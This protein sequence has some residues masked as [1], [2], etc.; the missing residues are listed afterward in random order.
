MLHGLLRQQHVLRQVLPELPVIK[1]L[2]L[3]RFKSIAAFVTGP[4][5]SLMSL[6]H[7]MNHGTVNINDLNPFVSHL[8]ESTLLSRPSLVIKSNVQR[9]HDGYGFLKNLQSR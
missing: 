9:Y 7:T 6:R 4:D 3:I 2:L 1:K 5:H 8:R